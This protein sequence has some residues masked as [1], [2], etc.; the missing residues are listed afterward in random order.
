MKRFQAE[1]SENSITYSPTYEAGRIGMIFLS[2]IGTLF[3]ATAICILLDHSTNGTKLAMLVVLPIAATILYVALRYLYQV[4]HIK[5]V[6]SNT[7]II[8]YANKNAEEK[9]IWWKDVEEVYFS[10]DPWYGRKSCRIFYSKAQTQNAPCDFVLPV[11]DVDEQNLL[12]LI[13]SHLWK[14]RPWQ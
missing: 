11:Y 2:V 3:I 12:Q 6:V 1:Y 5:I 4:M 13:P 7:G 10:Q 9:Q 14:N 8:Y